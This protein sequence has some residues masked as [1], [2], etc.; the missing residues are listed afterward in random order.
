MAVKYIVYNNLKFNSPIEVDISE[1][2]EDDQYLLVIPA[3]Y[4]VPTNAHSII[5]AYVAGYPVYVISDSFS[6]TPEQF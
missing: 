2:T 3:N 1:I 6:E 5:N 4:P